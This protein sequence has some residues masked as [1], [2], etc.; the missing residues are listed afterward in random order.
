MEKKTADL[1]GDSKTD[2]PRD[3]SVGK[4]AI[5]ENGMKRRNF[6]ALLLSGEW[7]SMETKSLKTIL[8]NQRRFISQFQKSVWGK[9]RPAVRVNDLPDTA[10]MDEVFFANT[11]SIRKINTFLLRRQ[12]QSAKKWLQLAK[13][14]R[15]HKPV[16]RQIQEI[17]KSHLEKVYLSAACIVKNE[18]PYIREWIEFHRDVGVD[19]IFVFDNESEDNTRQILQ[20]YIADGFVKYIYFPGKTVQLHAYNLACKLCR[21]TS[22]WLALIDAD[23]F[24]MPVQEE[25]LPQVLRSYEPYAGLG[26]NWVV[27]GPSGHEKK[28]DGYVIGNYR[29]TFADRNHEMNCRI[30]S[31]VQPKQVLA[32]MSPHHCWY[33]KGVFAVDEMANPIIGEAIYAGSGSMTCTMENHCGVIRINHYWTKSKE[34]LRQKCSRG[35]ADGNQNPVYDSIL[36]RLDFPMTEDFSI[37]RFL[38]RLS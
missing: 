5:A 30:K 22:H 24:L 12:V 4:E 8:E 21:R 29:M 31:V 37:E 25:T 17:A 32:V 11:D 23:E 7:K 28:P 26:V 27:Y 10:C 1:S 35:Y 15:A 14:M 19:R 20:P 38:D 34:E 6:T 9:L 3:D 36:K 16:R 33:K 18:G 2:L 13:Y